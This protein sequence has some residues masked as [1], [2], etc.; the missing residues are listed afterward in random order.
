MI[1]TTLTAHNRSSYVNYMRLLAAQYC[2]V[3]TQRQW[4]LVW[5]SDWSHL[6]G[7]VIRKAGSPRTH[8]MSFVQLKCSVGTNYY[9]VRFLKIIYLYVILLS[10][11]FGGGFFCFI[12]LCSVLTLMC[13]KQ[14][15]KL[16]GCIWNVYDGLIL[17]L[18]E[19][20]HIIL[21]SINSLIHSF[22][23][24]HSFHYCLV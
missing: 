3:S 22:I 1:Y 7:G 16:S 15:W 4:D 23:H 18:L 11:S 5:L 13:N 2:W 6:W 14:R 19:R 17:F 20:H 24:I 21:Q 10:S 12:S 9:I 8:G